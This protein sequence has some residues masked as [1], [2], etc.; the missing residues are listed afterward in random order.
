MTSFTHIVGGW[1]PN[2]G[3][4][5]F[6]VAGEQVLR[7]AAPESVIVRVGEKPGYP[8][9]WN[10]KGGNPKGYFDMAAAVASDYLVL[11]GPM[12]RPETLEI[13]GDSLEAIMNTGTRL[14]LL[15]AGAMRYDSQS[16]ASYRAFLR[17]FP[18]HLLVS[19]DSE[20]F[21]ALG[22]L[23]EHAHSGIDL[24]FFTS[25]QYPIV[26]LSNLGDFAAFSFD[27]MPEPRIL[28]GAPGEPRR[29]GDLAAFEWQGKTWHVRDH[30]RMRLAQRSRYAMFAESLVFPGTGVE[31]I[32][33]FPIVR[34]DHRY[35]PII[36]R[37][38]FRYPNV[39][40]ND[41]PWPY[42]ELYGSANLVLTD[43]IH[44]AVIGLSYGRPA[45]VFSKSP[46]LRLLERFGLDE[47][48]SRPMTLDPAVLNRERSAVKAFLSKHLG[49]NERGRS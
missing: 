27:K 13:W 21:E 46:R 7:D 40:V 18:P 33:G 17:R 8:Q 45:M 43:R 16:L 5:F 26:G 19:R 48:T 25:E 49:N 6:Q 22:D 42:Y 11:M 1:S 35:S 9:Y 3:N 38:T 39:F 30:W 41:T 31:S 24:A 47:I 2:I 44:A 15:G 14:I 12:F 23:A 4:A 37:R 36:K 20:T 10:P 29:G 34:A 32:D 28:L